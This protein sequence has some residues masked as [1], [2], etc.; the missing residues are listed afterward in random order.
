MSTKA[1][2]TPGRIP[3][4]SVGEM[5]KVGTFRKNVPVSDGAGGQKDSFTDVITVRGKLSKQSGRKALEQGEFVGNKGYEWI[6]RYNSVL[7]PDT[8]TIIVI[9][10]LQYRV[11]DWELIDEIKHFYRFT[12]SLNR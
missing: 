10:G 7:V 1:N 6:C 8:E 2:S 4:F 11:N 12:L 9:D 5:R 3:Y